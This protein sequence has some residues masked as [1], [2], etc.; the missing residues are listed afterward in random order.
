VGAQIID[1]TSVGGN[2]WVYAGKDRDDV[3]RV[4][5]KW[6]FAYKAGKGWWK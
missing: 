2:L 4:L 1:K 3:D 5:K 6:G